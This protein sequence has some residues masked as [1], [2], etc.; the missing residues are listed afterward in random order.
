[1]SIKQKATELFRDLAEIF[2][3]DKPLPI[4][5]MPPEVRWK[6][7]VQMWLGFLMFYVGGIGGLLLIVLGKLPLLA[8]PVV[9]F[10]LCAGLWYLREFRRGNLVIP[11]TLDDWQ[12]VFAAEKK[13]D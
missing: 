3:K 5:F 10:E 13:G 4:D 1:M 2:D 7:Q 11:I 6:F 8:I 12:P 9:I